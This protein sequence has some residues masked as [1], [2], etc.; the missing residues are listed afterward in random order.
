MGKLSNH[1]HKHKTKA[2]KKYEHCEM[3]MKRDKEHK[4]FED[5]PKRAWELLKGVN[6]FQNSALTPE[7]SADPMVCSPDILLNK[8]ELAFLK[9][10]PRFMLRQETSELEF[11]TE[12]EKCQLKKKC[13]P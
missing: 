7:D 2:I 5:I 8:A 10:G 4:D 6:L 11:K 1:R 3:K 13:Q 9:K 12:L